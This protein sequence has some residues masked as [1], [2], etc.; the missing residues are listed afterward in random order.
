[1]LLL[2]VVSFAMSAENSS[3][4]SSATD[5]SQTIADQIVKSEIPVL[6]DFWAAWCGPCKLL[7]PIL[8]EL[9]KE[10]KGKI[11]FMKVNVDIHKELSA[12]FQVQ[13]IPAVFLV[14]NKS[15]VKFLPGLQPKD[16]YSSAIKE[17][18]ALAKNPEVP[19]DPVKK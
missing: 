10:Y 17:V 11:L 14:H 12:Y 19:A 15:V 8:A 1:M 2:A 18:L 6:I 7:N 5:S 4:P 16:M 3:V 13:A 9:E